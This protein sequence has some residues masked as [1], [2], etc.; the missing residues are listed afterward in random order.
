MNFAVQ[1][2]LFVV[3]NVI[4]AVKYKELLILGGLHGMFG[5]ITGP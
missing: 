1:S 2:V 5:A 4:L 3:L